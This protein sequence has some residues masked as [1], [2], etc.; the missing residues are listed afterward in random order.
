V[1]DSNAYAIFSGLTTRKFRE[2]GIDIVGASDYM[3]VGGIHINICIRGFISSS[4]G[5]SSTLYTP[6][7][8]SSQLPIPTLRFSWYELGPSFGDPIRPVRTAMSIGPTE[9]EHLTGKKS[10]YQNRLSTQNLKPI[11]LSKCSYQ[12]NR[13]QI[14]L[15][16]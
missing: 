9:G 2:S 14:D 16:M 8:R 1:L 5:M 10:T 7:G 15:S 12:K 4:L 6:E 13:I 11:N 3:P